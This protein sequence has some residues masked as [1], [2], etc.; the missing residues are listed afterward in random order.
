[1]TSLD[2]SDVFRYWL[3]VGAFGPLGAAEKFMAGL[4]IYTNDEMDD[5]TAVVAALRARNL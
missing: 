2:H 1:L 3:G 5:A 4:A